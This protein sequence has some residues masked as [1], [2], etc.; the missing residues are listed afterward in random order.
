M[1]T[2]IFCFYLQNRLI[3]SSQTGGQQ[4]SDTSPFSTP[5]RNYFILKFHNF[6]FI[7]LVFSESN[8]SSIKNKIKI[9]IFNKLRTAMLKMVGV[10]FN[11]K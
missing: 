6:E 11:S 5:C 8:I 9:A 1:K 2:E 3:K 7:T 4:Y 10:K